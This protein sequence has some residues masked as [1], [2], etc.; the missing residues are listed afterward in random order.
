MAHH[1]IGPEDLTKS[2]AVRLLKEAWMT[3]R[4]GQKPMHQRSGVAV[5][6]HPGEDESP[7]EHYHETQADEDR[8]ARADLVDQT[9][10][11][12][13]PK[14]TADDLPKPVSRLL[15]KKGLA[16]KKTK[17]KKA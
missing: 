2:A 17:F 6:K 10:P 16:P 9:R 3:H 7:E 1:I 5:E 4:E 14:I 8:E 11:G 13:A 15:V 12:N